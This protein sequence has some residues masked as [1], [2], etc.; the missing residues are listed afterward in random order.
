MNNATHQNESHRF[1]FHYCNNENV[2]YQSH[3][4]IHFDLIQVLVIEH[5][6]E[7][8]ETGKPND[9]MTRPL[10]ELAVSLEASNL[11]EIEQIRDKLLCELNIALQYVLE[12]VWNN[13]LL[14]FEPSVGINLKINNKICEE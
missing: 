9:A 7:C 14:S 12:E 8:Y 10:Q 11:N 2:D 5:V 6:R 13:A 3:E 1:T 4:K